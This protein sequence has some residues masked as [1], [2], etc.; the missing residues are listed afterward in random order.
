MNDPN[1]VT[2][3]RWQEDGVRTPGDDSLCFCHTDSDGSIAPAWNSACDA[4]LQGVFEIGLTVGGRYRLQHMLGGGAMGR[5]F[6]AQDLRLGRLVAFKVVAHRPAASCNLETVLEREA[7]LGASLNHTGIAVVLDFGFHENKSYTVF[8]FVEGETLRA[9]LRRRGRIPL[10]ETQRIIQELAA[11][12]DYAHSHG[13]VHRDL[14]PENIAVTRRG[15][16]K[17][18]DLGIARDLRQE[19]QAA[20]YSGTPAYSSPEQAACR[21]TDGR[22]DQYTL[23]LLAYEMLTGSKVFVEV[24]V[25]RMLQQHM[26]AAPPD[27]RGLVEDLPQASACAILRG[28]SKRPQDR[29]PTCQDFAA[30][31]SEPNPSHVARHAVRIAPENRL[32][33]YLGH[34]LEES[35]L[36]GQLARGLE[37][38]GY[39][40]WCVG[41]NAHAGSPWLVQAQAAIERS[42]AVILLASRSAMRTDELRLEMEFARTVGCPLQCVLVDLSRE[43]FEETY[44]AWR[45]ILAAQQILD[46]ADVQQL[47]RLLDQLCD[48]AASLGMSADLMP[49]A[50]TASRPRPRTGNTWA[51]DANQIEIDALE[52]VVFENE[53]IAHFLSR[54]NK[55]F[56]IGTKGL[57][58]TLLL[59]RKRQ[60]LT[61]A[62]ADDAQS[63][64]LIPTGRPYLDFMSEMRTLS[65]KYQQPL[66]ELS[67]TKRLWSAALR[68][69]V[70]SHHPGV[71]ASGPTRS[72]AELPERI[73]AWLDNGRI[74]PTVVF[75]ELTSLSIGQLNRII[76]KC[77]N[78]LDERLRRIHAATYVFIDKVDQ[79][80]RHLTREA[81]IATQAGLIEAAWEIMNAN[82]HIKVYATIRQEA[83]ANYQSHTRS[84]LFGSTSTL[85]YTPHELRRLLD[86]LS[87]YYEGQTTFADF[88]GLEVL[89]HPHRTDPEETFQFVLRHTLGRPRDLVAI[90]SELSANRSHLSEAGLRRVV[91]RTGGTVI[92][93][94]IFDEVHV[95]LDCLGDEAT[96]R[97]FLGLIPGN[98]L[99]RAEAIQ[100][101]EEFNGLEPGTIPFLGEESPEIHHPFR[102]LYLA[103][104]LGCLEA[105]AATGALLQRFRQPYDSVSSLVVPESA[106]YFIHPALNHPIV[107]ARNRRPYLRMEQ[108][109]VGHQL[110]WQPLYSLVVAIERCA[111]TLA[112]PEFREIALS[113]A[114]QVLA[115]RE[116]GP[117]RF[118]R[119]KVEAHAAWDRLQPYFQRDQYRDACRH[120]EDMLEAL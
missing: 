34:G 14:K 10:R 73:L 48:V 56:L 72:L 97:R 67:T 1:L 43:L 30:A 63:L 71:M 69:S 29:F 77:E 19:L 4:E 51:T 95:F 79:A 5:V 87:Q 35:I 118:A 109:P 41:R 99:T 11:A 96:R 18:L 60:L 112:D 7:R 52:R 83:F 93:A 85:E 58:K 59:T 94:S 2:T 39:R 3:R 17:L 78:E 89:R 74:E 115:V 37:G 98:I 8:E 88:L 70:I 84:N 15:E 38:R 116:A 114:A 92:V 49:S 61:A 65:S 6:L 26:H 9:L 82:S 81:W 110:P 119:E 53:V 91:E 106:Y 66:S 12:L 45:T 40:T 46:G 22:S 24:D 90:A 16:V 42:Q 108:V 113:V 102:D 107:E 44:P 68:I 86:G 31:L 111:H 32:E 104:L 100:I 21:H 28:L 55:H 36:A 20:I 23:A 25:L 105:D 62:A 57:G 13:I 75:K 33:F 50:R 117:S 76:D 103:G 80:I 101:C 27:P 47:D 54:R 120:I 64:T